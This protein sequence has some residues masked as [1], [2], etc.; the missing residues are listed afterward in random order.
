MRKK[1]VERCCELANKKDRAA[2]QKFQLPV[3]NGWT[4]EEYGF[5]VEEID[6][7]RWSYEPTSF[8]DPENSECTRRECNPNGIIIKKHKETLESLIS[9]GATENCQSG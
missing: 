3:Q 4:K 7:K 6:E 5:H 2:T 9:A 8:L 1:C